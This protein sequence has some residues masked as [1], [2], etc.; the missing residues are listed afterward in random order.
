MSGN[1]YIL[2]AHHCCR[3]LLP[4]TGSTQPDFHSLRSLPSKQFCR[5]RSLVALIVTD[6]SIH[7]C[8]CGYHA[9][10]VLLSA[11]YSLIWLDLIRQIRWM[12]N[13]RL[14]PVSSPLVSPERAI[15]SVVRS[16]APVW[17]SYLDRH[18]SL[19][20]FAFSVLANLLERTLS[21][22]YCVHTTPLSS[23]SRISFDDGAI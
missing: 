4:T 19:D 18:S 20:N 11:H 13:V 3:C 2:E 7:S 12:A 15:A 6:P 21:S 16:V 5:C 17:S 10:T 22:Q 1:G 14:C 9:R 23:T 8:L